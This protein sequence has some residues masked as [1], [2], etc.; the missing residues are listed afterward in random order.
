M[1]AVRGTLSILKIVSGGQSGVDRAALDWAIAHDIP[2]GGW[3]PHG[4]L[5]ADGPLHARYQLMETE[6]AGY[7][8]R[9]KRNV[10]DSD[11]TLILNTGALSGGSLLT[12]RFALKLGKPSW[13]LQ[14][15]A[16]RFDAWD[17]TLAWL[18]DERPL[19]LNIAGPGETKRPGIHAQAVLALDR[20]FGGSG[21]APRSLR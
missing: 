11:A 7:S 18:A 19:V 16:E 5:A 3:C 17:D 10:A 8:Q 1:A 9:T 21:A 20:L 13:V 4:R 14:I 6:S 2:H 12:K 15:D